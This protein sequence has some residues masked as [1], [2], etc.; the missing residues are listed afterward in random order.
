MENPFKM[1]DLGGTTILDI[2][3]NLHVMKWHDSHQL[4]HDIRMNTNPLGLIFDD[5]CF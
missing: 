3:G 4:A 2:L 5:F 1:D